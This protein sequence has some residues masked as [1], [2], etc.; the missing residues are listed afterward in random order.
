[1]FQCL[2]SDNIG[3]DELFEGVVR[4]KR[5]RLRVQREDGAALSAMLNDSIQILF[6]YDCRSNKNGGVMAAYQKYVKLV[7]E[8][9]NAYILVA[10]TQELI[11]GGF[12]LLNGKQLTTFLC[13]NLKQCFAVLKPFALQLLIITVDAR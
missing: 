13:E 2:F 9:L 5:L 12:E 11:I 10:L 8:S 1:M 7:P 6:V 3:A 4:E